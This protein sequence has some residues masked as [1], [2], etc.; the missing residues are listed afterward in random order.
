MKMKIIYGLNFEEACKNKLRLVEKVPFLIVTRKTA[1]VKSEDSFGG[2]DL[3]V[4][5]NFSVQL[6]NHHM[7]FKY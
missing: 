7:I 3:K 5:L 2:W 4:L 1:M 6:T